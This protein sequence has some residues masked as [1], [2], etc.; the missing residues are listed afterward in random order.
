MVNGFELHELLFKICPETFIGTREE[1]EAQ[2]ARRLEKEVFN[3]G[4]LPRLKARYG[5]C[6][7]ERE[8]SPDELQGAFCDAG[9]YQGLDEASRE[10]SET[11]FLAVR[12]PSPYNQLGRELR[13]S[14]ISGE[15]GQTRYRATSNNVCFD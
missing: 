5:I 12:Y 3:Q 13:F 2:G 7:N 1:K 15:D 11:E 14:R 10:L 6:R 8:L 4:I 9:V